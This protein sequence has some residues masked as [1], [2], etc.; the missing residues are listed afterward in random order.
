[1]YFLSLQRQVQNLFLQYSLLL[2]FLYKTHVVSVLS[3]DNGIV[4]THVFQIPIRAGISDKSAWL[5]G[6]VKTGDAKKGGLRLGF[7][8]LVDYRRSKIEQRRISGGVES[9][10]GCQ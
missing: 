3:G 2:L 9:V 6:C 7:Q 1:M 4:A 10:T 5:A 8:Q